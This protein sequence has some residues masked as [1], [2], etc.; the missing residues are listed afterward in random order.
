[1]TRLPLLSPKIRHNI[2]V[3]FFAAFV[4]VYLS[5]LQPSGIVFER[6]AEVVVLDQSWDVTVMLRYAPVFRYRMFSTNTTGSPTS[7]DK[8]TIGRVFIGAA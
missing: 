1:M 3:V 4:V 2:I 5:I 6:Y 8:N 7:R